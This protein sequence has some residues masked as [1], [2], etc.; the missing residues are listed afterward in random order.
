MLCIN[1]LIP[2]LQ[3]DKAQ[4][5]CSLWYATLAQYEQKGNQRAPSHSHLP[6]PLTVSRNYRTNTQ[7]RAIAFIY[8]DKPRIKHSAGLLPGS[9][10]CRKWILGFIIFGAGATV[11]IL[12]SASYSDNRPLEA[13][14]PEAEAALL[15]IINGNYIH[16]ILDKLI[17]FVGIALSYLLLSYTKK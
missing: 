5:C 14:Y 7:A 15:S 4:N 6:M 13:I 2:S 12:Q 11:Y 8:M 10:G 16:M 3:S 1:V 9:L 17:I